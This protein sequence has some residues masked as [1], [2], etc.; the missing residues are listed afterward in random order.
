[1]NEL[2]RLTATEA[3]DL[4]KKGDITSIK[5]LDAS[6]ERIQEVEPMINALPIKC[7]DR[8]RERANKISEKAGKYQNHPGWI[9][10][11]PVAVKDL[12]HVAGVPTTMGGSP[13]FKDFVP[14]K[15]SYSVQNM[16]NRGAVVVAKSNS[17]EFGFNATTYNTLWGY[18]NNPWDVTRSTAGSSGGSAASLAAGEVWL[19]TGSDLGASIRA[20]AAFCSIV[21]LRPTPG[22]VPR[23]PHPLPFNLLPVEG[24][25]ARTVAD[26]ALMLENMTGKHHGD[27][28]SVDPVPGSY[29]KAIREPKTPKRIGFSLD[30]GIT[31]VHSEVAKL[32]TQAAKRFVDM[33]VEVTDSC[34]DFSKAI[35]V[36]HGI[37]GTNHIAGMSVYMENS[38][39]LLT[40]EIIWSV[41]NARKQTPDDIARAEK[42]R[43]E[44]VQ[45]TTKFFDEHDFL[46]CPAAITPPF[47]NSWHSVAEIEGY[48]FQT[49]IDWIA[50]T[51]AVTLT[52]C[53][54]ISVPCGFTH[55]GLPVGLQIIGK[56]RCEA[57]LLSAAVLF[58]E[59]VGLGRVT[60]ID[61][62][63]PS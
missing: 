7:F 27:P 28:I 36:F 9:A 40:P 41:E 15:S 35:R 34:P 46:I 33:G 59:A 39:E 22:C 44:L 26:V 20:P 53:P 8:A 17:P 30:L 43:G 5:L 49:Y 60:P 25:M 52:A 1:M 58:E 32:V 21:G 19:A 54:A 38:R 45:S 3:V 12:A 4:L 51:F 6:I 47:P 10:G 48:K 62:K 24:P 14:E 37:R 57:E 63:N 29:L 16:E 56:P 2:I 55:E 42:G 31:K 18:T 50:I 11:L 13:I 61:P 23:G